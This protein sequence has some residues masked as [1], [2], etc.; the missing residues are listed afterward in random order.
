MSKQWLMHFEEGNQSLAGLLGGKGANLAEM[1]RAGLAVPPGFTITTE[2]CRAYYLESRLPGGLFREVREAMTVLEVRKG[3]RFGDAAA[4]LLVSVRSG[5]VT[6]MPGMMDTILNLGL[7]D[8]TVQGLAAATNNPR[9]AYDCYRRLIQMFG[10]V[11]FGIEGAWFEKKLHALKEAH[12]AHSDQSVTAEAWQ[13]LI[14]TYKSLILKRAGTAFPQDVYEQLHMAVEAVF[15]SWNN[16]RAQI[17]RRLN[18]IPDEQGTAVNIQAMVFGNLNE[19]SGTGV[20]FTRNPSTGEGVLFGEY[21]TN[22]QGEDVVA[23]VRTPQPIAGLQ[24]D[25]PAIY[26]QLVAMAGLLEKHYRDMQDIEFTIENGTLYMLQTRSGKRTAQAAMRIAVELVRAGILTRE[27]AL[28]RVEPS[29]L[30]Q[31]LHPSLDE[32]AAPAALGTG[33]PASPGAACGQAVFTADEAQEQARSGKAVI[34]VRTETTPEDI[35]GVL[36]ARGVLTSRGG[37][38]S[39][40]AVVARGMGKPCVCGCEAL[41]I[42]AKQ[43]RA[44]IGGQTIAEGDW[45]TIDGA[46]GRVMIGEVPLKEAD[47]SAE[48]L[49]MLQWADDVRGM[50]VY[51]NADNPED[52]AKA[53]SFGAEGVGLCRTEHMFLSPQRLPI[54]QKMILADTEAVRAEALGELL[55]MQRS[56]FAAI[57]RAMAGLPVTIRLLDP[58]LHEFLPNLEDLLTRHA[59]LSAARKERAA[60]TPETDE[61]PGIPAAANSNERSSG[62]VIRSDVSRES[63]P[64]GGRQ[65]PESDLELQQLE[66]LIRKVRGLH[67]VN[68]MLGQR[69]CRLG[70]LFPEIYGMQIEAIFAAVQDCIRDGIEVSPEIMI[71][72][73]GHANELRIMRELVDQVAQKM[74]GDNR[75]AVPYRVGTMIEVPRAALTAPQI[76]AHADFFSFGTNDLTQMTFGYSRDDAEGKFLTHYVDNKLLPD[77]PFQVLDRDGVGQLIDLAV[78]R[79]RAL[80]PKLKTGVCGEH[81]GDPKSI[82]LCREMGLDYVSCSPYRVPIARIAAAQAEIEAAEAE[83]NSLAEQQKIVS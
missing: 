78:T 16:S 22:A 77:N 36:A 57:F 29:H 18:G 43:R 50:K 83:K 35:H 53:R 80:K 3:Q 5:S 42:H 6:S 46:T 76:A 40:A 38:T 7:N 4:P 68:P 41:V 13:E 9:F 23:G 37:M 20:V 54:V 82:R 63:I 58:P 19:A 48:L 39:H 25:M 64:A 75:N 66:A 34:L 1:T 17:Y 81:G 70:I 45:L 30:D 31:L 15:R 32:S 60:S 72:L 62:P 2:A 71:P 73:V 33:L 59:H 44:V 10:T 27:E 12:A 11:V 24:Q 51:A 69:G 55:P 14:G 8:E 28:M 49:E 61:S 26:E 56:D 21:L 79:A 74:L 65:S 47:M 52:A 67:E